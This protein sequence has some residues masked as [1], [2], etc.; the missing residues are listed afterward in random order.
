MS[1]AAGMSIA[2]L[3]LI[4]IYVAAEL[5]AWRRSIPRRTSCEV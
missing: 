5:F 1:Y 4:A 3:L 2:M